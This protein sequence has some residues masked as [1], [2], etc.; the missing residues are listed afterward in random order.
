M[1]QYHPFRLPLDINTT[2]DEVLGSIP[3]LSRR[4]A[5]EIVRYR[6]EIKGFES[7]DELCKLLELTADEYAQIAP[8]IT[9][10]P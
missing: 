2:S 9:V 5:A 3:G 1:I 8:Y 6:D 4:K 7:L 10:N